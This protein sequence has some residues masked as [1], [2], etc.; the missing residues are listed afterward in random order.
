MRLTSF[1]EAALLERYTPM[2]KHMI[3]EYC[4]ACS[5]D[6]LNFGDDLLQEAYVALLIH[7]RRIESEDEIPLAKLSMKGAICASV[8][9]M[10][11]VYYPKHAAKKQRNLF[12]FVSYEDSDLLA[13]GISED[14]QLFD[15]SFRA[16]L[17]GLDV[18]DRFVLEKKLEGCSHRE[19]VSQFEINNEMMVSR[20]LGKLR[21]GLRDILTA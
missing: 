8:R 13:G 11:D 20:I 14:E 7:I 16:F 17:D 19:L 18:R 4:E 5:L 21:E 15:I 3:R 10:A 12:R 6:V 1:E 9:R 2:A